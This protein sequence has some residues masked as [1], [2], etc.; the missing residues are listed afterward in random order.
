MIIVDSDETNP[1]FTRSSSGLHL[2][3]SYDDL[4]NADYDVITLYI[5]WRDQ[6]RDGSMCEVVSKIEGLTSRE[7]A[8]GIVSSIRVKHLIDFFL[9]FPFYFCVQFCYIVA[10]E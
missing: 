1:L 7:A 6:D 4:S 5:R 9:L 8:K 10:V 2:P 3:P